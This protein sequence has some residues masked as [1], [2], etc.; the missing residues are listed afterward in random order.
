M[1]AAITVVPVVIDHVFTPEDDLAAILCEHLADLVWPDG[2]TG[3]TSGDVVVV[4][5][6]IVAKC[7]GRVIEAANR[8]AAI[9]EQ[10][11][12]VVAVKETPRGLTTIGQTRHGLVMAA[13]GVDASNTNPGTVVLLPEDPDASAASLRTALEQAFDVT[14]AV[15]ITDTMGRPWRLGV[16]DVAIGASG[17]RV[18]DDFT[19][20]VD[21]YGNRLEMTVVAVADEIAS[22]AELASAKLAGAPVSVV[23]GLDQH[24]VAGA[25]GASALIR[26]LEEDLFSLGTREAR[27]EGA[28]GAATLRRTVRAFADRAVDPALVHEAIAAAITAPAPHGSEPWR[29]AVLERDDRRR[30]LLDA[31]RTRWEA[32]LRATPGIDPASIPARLARGDLLRTAPCVVLPFVDLAAGA[33]DYPDA[34]RMAA[35][36]DMFTIAGGAAVSNLMVSLAANGL[37]SAWIGSTIFCPDIV[38]EQLGLPMS[39]MPLGAIAIGWPAEDWKPKERPDRD[40]AQYLID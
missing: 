27:I 26:P 40:P 31:M 11:V 20:R 36:R 6:K 1:T 10:T 12:R 9:R 5:S 30:H 16:A 33:H 14:I 15:V 4:T 24:V 18:L 29:F 13:A 23:R 35:E 19:G 28:R 17:L 25:G 21:S 8:D 34:A 7:E 22:A 32:D 39:V 3:I 38:R 2:S 37:G